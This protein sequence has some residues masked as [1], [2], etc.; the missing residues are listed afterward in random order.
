MRLGKS[1][2]NLELIICRNQKFVQVLSWNR[3]K[4]SKN[5]WREIPKVWSLLSQFTLL[6]DL[7]KT[8]NSPSTRLHYPGTS[9]SG[10]V[11]CQLRITPRLFFQTIFRH[12][13][14][15]CIHYLSSCYLAMKNKRNKDIPIRKISCEDWYFDGLHNIKNLLS[16][17]ILPT[18]QCITLII[19]LMWL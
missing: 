11:P 19:I 2:A 14:S 9:N 16:E 4:K 6:C 15:I 1:V 18:I 13:T 7:I 17:W 3:Y 10:Y 5:S 8:E 12:L